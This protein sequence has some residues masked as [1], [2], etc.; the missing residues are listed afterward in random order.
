MTDE[1]GP[2]LEAALS[3]M[4]RTAKELP[5][6]Y[7]AEFIL[8]YW[9][10][11]IPPAEAWCCSVEGDIMGDSGDRLSVLGHTATEALQRAA[12]EA[13]RRVPPGKDP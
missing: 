11:V 6:A 12:A 4:V 5:G 7:R 1:L 8:E 3:E 10:G 13:W 2:G 9:G